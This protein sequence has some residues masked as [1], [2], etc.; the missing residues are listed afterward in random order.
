MR[1]LPWERN[2]QAKQQQQKQQRIGLGSPAPALPFAV[3]KG[4]F[5][6]L[7][8]LCVLLV[9]LLPSVGLPVE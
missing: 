3:L 6:S 9:G 8:P 2:V 4:G 1:L 5:S 7:A